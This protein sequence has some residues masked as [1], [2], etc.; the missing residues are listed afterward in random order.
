[1]GLGRC[2]VVDLGSTGGGRGGRYIFARAAA[3]FA[4]IVF[5]ATV[6]CFDRRFSI[7]AST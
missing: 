1:L 6:M 7:F 2:G 3:I 4:P 5:C